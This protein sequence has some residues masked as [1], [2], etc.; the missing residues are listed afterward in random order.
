MKIVTCYKLVP[1][2][3]DIRVA[4]DRTLDLSGAAWKVGQYDLNAV[5][6]A[7]NIAKEAAGSEVIALTCGGEI[8]DNSK[9]KKSILSRGPQQM[10]GIM[11]ESLAHADSYA[12]ANVLKTAV[13]NIGDVDLIFCGEGSGDIY[14]QQVGSSLGALLGWTTVNAVNA[15]SVEEDGKLLVERALETGVEVLKV[16]LPA[17]LSVTA[18]INTPRIPSM[19]EIMG[20]GKKPMKVISLAESGA[21]VV[22]GAE[23][24]SILAPE[25]A[26]RQRLILGEGT[27]ENLDTLANYIRK[28]I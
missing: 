16:T 19:K 22:N 7:M 27:E 11:D 5:E 13:E 8:V 3:N 4:D 20:A 26:G 2:E 21:E 28:A 24:E 6:A 10:V 25:T 1:E 9:L 23:V 14:S 15:V 17:V 12:V 18:G